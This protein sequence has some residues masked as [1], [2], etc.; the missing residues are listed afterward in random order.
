MNRDSKSKMQIIET[1]AKSLPGDEFILV[2]ECLTKVKH[3]FIAG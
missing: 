1:V 3:G 2:I